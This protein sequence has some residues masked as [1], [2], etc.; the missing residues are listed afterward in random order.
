MDYSINRSILKML[1]SS[2]LLSKNSPYHSS[3]GHALTFLRSVL[4]I[5]AEIAFKLNYCLSGLMENF[6]LSPLYRL[7]N[8][9]YAAC[10]I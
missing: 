6:S 8:I 5:K 4:W 1:I 7:F 9:F 3:L 2:P 10:I